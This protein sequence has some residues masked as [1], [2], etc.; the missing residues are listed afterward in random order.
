MRIQRTS[1]AAFKPVLRLILAGC[2]FLAQLTAS[3]STANTGRVDYAYSHQI[4]EGDSES[5]I[6]E[7]AAKVLP[8]P[9]QLQWMRLE[10]TFFLH[11]G[12]NTF[13]GVEW[14][15]GRES[16]ALFAPDS[17]DARQWA[18]AVK[19]AGGKL[20]ILVAKHHDGLCL[21]PTRYTQHSVASSPWRKGKGDLVRE[22]ADAAKAEGLKL[23]IYLSPADLYQLRT[24]PNNPGGLY[25]NGSAKRRSTIPTEP[26]SFLKEPSIGR[27]VP[28]GNL[29]QVYEL[30]DYNRYFLN[31]LHELL[32]EY[33]PI[34]V[35]WFDGANPDP[36]VQQS[37]D[38]KAWYDLIRK[39]QPEAT[40]S[41]K[42]P[43]VRWVGN[44]GGYGRTT[45]WSVLPLPE[46]P[47]VHDWP[48][49]Q[50]QDLGSRSKL[51]PGSHLWWYPAEVNTPI[52]N[53]WFWAPGKRTKS[54]AEL[55][56]YYYRS[57]GRNGTMLLNLS[58]DTHGL[59]PE[60]QL[61]ALK[62][63][64]RIIRDTFSSDLAKGAHLKADSS[65]PGHPAEL[66]MDGN[67]DTWWEAGRGSNGG[68]L[69][70]ELPK[71]SRFDVVSLQEAVG[72]RSQRIESF[73]VEVWNGS[74]WIAPPTLEEQ[75][76]VGYK[77]LV[78]LA[79]PATTKRVR[80][81]ITQ[82]RLEPTLAEVGLF[83]QAL[84][85]EPAISERDRQGIVTLSH[86]HARPILY[87]LDGTEP[88]LTSPRYQAPLFLPE[89]GTVNAAIL[90][91]E[92]KL[93]LVASKTFVGLA[94]L[95]WKIVSSPSQVSLSDENQ[96]SNAIDAEAGTQWCE[97]AATGAEPPPTLTI[98]MGK[99]LE[100]GGLAYLPRQ[101]WVF[102]GVVD[103]YHFETSIDGAE[104]TKQVESGEFGNIRNNPM[105]Q[106]FRF[107]SPVRA[108][109]FRFT[110]LR[111][112][113]NNGW[114]GAAE[115]T[116]LP[117]ASCN[118]A[119]LAPRTIC[120][121]DEGWRFHLGKEPKAREANFDDS[122]WRQV[123]VPHDYVVEGSFTEHNPIENKELDPNWYWLHGFLPLQPAVYR[124]SFTVP[125]HAEG[126]RFWLEFDGVFSNSR[127]WLNGSL[128]GSQYS[129][130]T[131]S[132][133]DI[134]DQVIPGGTNVVTVEVDP[135]YDGWW[136]EGGGIYRHV[137]LVTVD[138]VHLTPD[139]VFVAA[140][141][142]GPLGGGRADAKVD[143]QTEVTNTGSSSV[144]VLVRSEILDADGRIL[145]EASSVPEIGISS[146]YQVK[147]ALQIPQAR[148]WSPDNPALYRL[149]STV[150]VEGRITD[151][152][153]TTFGVRQLRFDAEE[154][155]FLNGKH[156]KLQGINMH[157]DHAGV[158]VAVPDRLFTW[159]FERLKEVG[160]NAI[161][162]SHN[163]VPPF[164][165]D[166]CDRLGFLVIA[167]N[168]HLGDSHVDQTPVDAVAVQHR[169]LST[170]IR[171]DRNHPSIMLWSLCNEQWIQ[172][173]PESA[174]MARA[175]KARVLE[176]DPTRPV[177]AAMNGGF[178]SAVGLGS[179]LDVIGI[180]YNPWVYDAVHR[181]FPKTPI[182]ASETAS[183]ICTRGIYKTE[184]WENYFGDRERGYVTAYSLCAGPAGQ[185]VENSWPQVA[186]RS[187]IGGG[188]V[189]SA[190]DYKGEPR[191]FGWP[192]INCHFGFMDICGFPKDS[193][194]YYKAH[195]TDSPVLHLFPHWNWADK[196]G[197]DVQVW[198][199]TNCD[200]VELLLNGQSLGR[201]QKRP[202]G[203]LEWTVRYEPGQLTARGYRNGEL[204][205]V[206]RETT[207]EG[208]AVRLTADRSELSADNADLAVVQVEVIDAQGR[209]VPIADNKVQ[210]TL[211]G[212]GKLIGVGN[213]D[214]S[215]HE[216]DKA[217][218]RS[219][220]NGLA[221]A[222]IQTT[223][224]PGQITLK[225]EAPG[226]KPCSL[227]L[228]SK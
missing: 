87:T 127:Y 205:E 24:N 89:G 44:E 11:F 71:E 145:A 97:R 26:Q 173:T 81:R 36:S 66:A 180:N 78:R 126:R 192:V 227:I 73:V 172:A 158:G 196:K 46:D 170:M 22:V 91:A 120:S 37:Y 4:K 147:Q 109:F 42:G 118:S 58:P 30:D 33:G 152:S 121:L 103:R 193:Y 23:G 64:T 156:L 55:V 117:L 214:P 51:V 9:R 176:L 59:I 144:S 83:C 29:S 82:C 72:Q 171:R 153:T 85:R 175:M 190:F 164:L 212:P 110:A 211:S 48:D 226:L 57:V 209:L 50:Q 188:F 53:G 62:K 34:S 123:D 8:R 41:V 27:S 99:I 35:V 163:P 107:K 223:R 182:I 98:D 151:Q 208:A 105:L 218:F 189:W 191:P 157:Q 108:R 100:I 161:R 13:R 77:R 202:L 217:D 181:L 69:T 165:L 14:G 1:T 213:G 16:P 210:F 65:E 179:A 195:W 174:A 143:V 194:F 61:A 140:E 101:D 133:F 186:N 183:E 131:R 31:Q 184:P 154:G 124:K 162:M 136:Y 96:A 15:D 47:S 135:R 185:T 79:S 54:T 167:E 94:P 68:L 17:L 219:V 220:F 67:P 21:W 104:W 134:T 137:R 92:G 216:P 106:E 130:Y 3:E 86:P 132:R 225:A 88:S 112:V 204:V 203:H 187:Y 2:A 199:H 75:S 166:E 111:A 198:V 148:L 141:P 146:G 200:E 128:I 10:Q 102:K 155:F 224:E 177:T 221:Q 32:T 38:Y 19:Q 60:D 63:R 18:R 122:S 6:L 40:I 178:D 70:L 228:R 197:Q 5:L 49:R 129:G 28:R 206:T 74:D 43:D 95:G 56:D 84:P 45:E 222:I 25:G 149:R 125:A 20:L 168:R 116:V 201:K 114:V 119:L 215:S 139:G 207:G 150:V 93:G 142:T 76:T 12:P 7:K 115:I 160:C 159:R 52:L 113:E 80:I 90:T 169:D 138:A 39:L